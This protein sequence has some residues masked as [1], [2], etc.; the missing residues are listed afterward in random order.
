MDEVE[1]IQRMENR[2][3]EETGRRA[4]GADVLVALLN[5]LYALTRTV[6]FITKDLKLHKLSLVELIVD[7]RFRALVDAEIDEEMA[8]QLTARIKG[9]EEAAAHQ[10]VQLSIGTH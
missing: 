9:D 5:D 1:Y 7:E 2:F 6:N 3:F 10:L 4:R 8:Q